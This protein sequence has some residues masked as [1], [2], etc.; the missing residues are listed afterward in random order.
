[1][2]SHWFNDVW[3][4]IGDGLVV[5]L[6]SFVRLKNRAC[7]S[8]GVLCSDKDHGRSMRPGVEDPKWSH[9]SDSRWPNDREVGWRRVWSALC[10]WRWGERVSWLSLKT[11]VYDLSVVLSQNHCDSF[12][13]F[14][15]KIG[16][17]GFSS[18]SSKPVAMVSWLSLKIGSYDLVIWVS[19]SP[20]QLLILGLKPKQASVCRLCHKI[21]S[22]MRRRGT[23]VEI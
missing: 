17:D 3:I 18:L 19:K 23:R 7:L 20:W 4:R 15:V 22:R 8:C 10:T 12:L 21:G 11:K 16:D 14:G 5:L 9:R 2:M 1:M 13:R 6:L